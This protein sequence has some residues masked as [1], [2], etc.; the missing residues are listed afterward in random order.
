MPSGRTLPFTIIEHEFQGL[1]R[2]SNA[3]T[4]DGAS[5]SASLPPRRLAPYELRA[6]LLERS[7]AYETQDA[8]LGWLLGK[9]QLERD[10]WIVAATGMVLPG[11]RARTS[12]LNSVCRS[13]VSELQTEVVSAVVEAVLRI[14]PTADKIASKL[15]WAGFKGGHRFA[16][17]YRREATRNQVGV[18]PASSHGHPD[19]VLERAVCEGVIGERDAAII[20]ETRL[21]GVRL[22][23]LAAAGGLGYEC[24]SKRRHRAE[25]RL[26]AWLQDEVA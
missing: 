25:V 3:L 5:I 9:A 22:A 17:T 4:I 16:T 15:V 23:D 24:V 21:G 8:A 6:V 26:A 1:H 10:A 18:V 19:L 11:L 14:R 2:A 13:R 7:T 12:V 20:G